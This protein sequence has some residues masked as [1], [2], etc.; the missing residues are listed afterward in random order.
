MEDFSNYNGE[1]TILRKAQL[2][3]LDILI[4]VD[5][6]CRK[7]DIPYWID[8]GT[9]LGAVRHGGFIPWDDDLDI[10]LMRKD[11]KRLCKIL[12]KE[13][14]D[15]LV[16][17]DISTDKYYPCAFAKVRDKKSFFK[18]PTTHPKIKE[19]GI[20]IDIFPIEKGGKTV[21]RIVDFFYINIFMRM[22]HHIKTNI[23]LYWLACALWLPMRGVVQLVRM[24]YFFAP[25]DSYIFGF[26]APYFSSFRK[27]DLVPVQP[28]TF[29]ERE[30][31]GPAN[32]EGYLISHYGDY[33][34]IPPEEE[35]VVHSTEIV[36]Y[37]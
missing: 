26:G 23:L 25:I 31:L 35:R 8:G 29:E 4:E 2:R 15:N 13:L 22:Q 1:G 5:K 34:Q 36:F 14:P 32:P 28:I 12:P 21:K 27:K 9:C 19:Q 3:M 20:Y 30:F 7:H 18:D 10:G 24:F 16:F 6:I 17:Q 33:M 11:F 37:E